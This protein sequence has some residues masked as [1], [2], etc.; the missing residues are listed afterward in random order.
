MLCCAANHS[1]G[2]R[3]QSTEAVESYVRAYPQLCDLTLVNILAELYLSGG[4]FE[5]TIQ[6]VVRAVCH[7]S[8]SSIRWPLQFPCTDSGNGK[9]PT[10]LS[11]FR[12]LPCSRLCVQ[13]NTKA[14][15]CQ[16]DAALPLDLLAK[17]AISMLNIGQADRA[18]AQ[19]AVLREASAE[20]YSDL[21][22]DVAEAFWAR[23]DARAALELLAPLRGVPAC[24]APA[25][26]ERIA[27]CRVKLGDVAGA[28]AE[29][30]SV[31]SQHPGDP[32]ALAAL[33]KLLPELVRARVWVVRLLV[34]RSWLIRSLG[35]GARATPCETLA[36]L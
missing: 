15:L 16:G 26:W 10:L 12:S 27:V 22:R 30:E 14:T 34:G 9:S 32:D 5:D 24:D 25:L 6:L 18:A 19:V 31:L 1:S 2:R 7:K 33:A 3:V 4:R 11:Q 21:F 36:W 8:P 35:G 28:V 23:G 20:E 13:E 17:S 29:Y